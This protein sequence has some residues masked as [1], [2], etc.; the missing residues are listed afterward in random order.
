MRNCF[1]GVLPAAAL[2]LAC[3]GGCS[4]G[5]QNRSGGGSSDKALTIGIMP[6]LV[7]IDFFNAV[8]KGALEAGRELEV[9][10]VYDGPVVNDV[11]KQSALVE[12]WMA[13]KFDAI[14]IAPNDPDAIA[15]VLRKAQ[16]RGVAVLTFDADANPGSRGYFVNQCTYDAVARSLVE[17]M[18]EGIGPEG[19]YIYLTGSLTAVN[20]NIWMERMEVYR[21]AKYPKM[22]NL[23]DTPKASEEDQALATQATIDILKSYPDVQGIYAMTSVALPGA[24]EAL[25]KEKAYDRVFLTGLSTPN[26]MREYVREGVVKKF[27]LWNPVDLG[28]LA[29]HAAKAVL[30]GTLTENTASI[31]AGRLGQIQVAGR[32]VLLGDPVVFDAGNID[33]FDF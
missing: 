5:G 6:K 1:Q 21:K 2:F 9:N 26:S 8:E 33:E 19:K 12:S 20:Q 4:G 25:R 17:T 23:S 3:V 10:V 31:T 18:V 11:T 15:P 29:I 14:V 22:Q 32:E 13:R 30:D 16:A 7:G 24:A 27:V 28:Y